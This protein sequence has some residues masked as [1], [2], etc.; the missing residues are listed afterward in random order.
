MSSAPPASFTVDL[1]GVLPELHFSR[2]DAAVTALTNPK[3]FTLGSPSPLFTLP[4]RR[5]THVI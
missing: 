3:R 4:L 5:I 1:D 2:K